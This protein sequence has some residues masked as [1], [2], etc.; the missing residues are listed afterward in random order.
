MK[1]DMFVLWPRA[2]W[3]IFQ[4]KWKSRFDAC[5]ANFP[6]QAYSIKAYFIL[7]TSSS[8]YCA[9]SF[10]QLHVSFVCTISKSTNKFHLTFHNTIKYRRFVCFC[11]FERAFHSFFFFCIYFS[12]HFVFIY[13]IFVC[14]SIV[15]IRVHRPYHSSKRMWIFRRRKKNPNRQ[16][17]YNNNNNN[18]QNLWGFIRSTK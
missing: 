8:A 6:I 13:F 11:A 15:I 9:M 3:D 5:H 16:T 12:I 1:L 10:K 2:R 18:N 17:D 14:S 4:T 7:M